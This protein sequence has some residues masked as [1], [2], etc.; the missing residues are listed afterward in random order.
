MAT[1]SSH[2]KASATA[3][4]RHISYHWQLFVPLTIAMW[5]VVAGMGLWQRH[6]ME[7]INDARVREPL[8]FIN[9]RTI[10]AYEN[11]VDPLPFIN[12]MANYYKENPLYKRVCMSVYRDGKLVYNVGDI[13]KRDVA[14]ETTGEMVHVE[15]N[16]TNFFYK[17]GRTSDGR[18]EVYSMMPFDEEISVMLD[19]KS[20]DFWLIMIIIAVVLTV[21]GYY[22]TRH[23]GRNIS[24]LRNFAQKAATS[25][26]FVPS[27]DYAHD[28]LGEISRQIV[29]IYKE[30]LQA[31]KRLKQEHEVAMHAMEEKARV[32]RQLTNNI[33]HELK[34]P[35]GVI[36]GYLDTIMANPDMD[37]A[38][39]DHFLAKAQQHAD[40]L[41]Q[42]VA[43]VTA[44][45]RLQ[46]GGSMINVEDMDFHDIV[47]G[48]ASD[49]EESGTIGDMTFEDDVRPGTYVHGN[50]N[51]LSGMLMNLVRNAVAY[52][53]GTECGVRT[54][55][56]DD[57]FYY[58]EFYDDGKGV[59]EEHLE[60]LFERF[61]RIDAG[62]SRK[63]GGT[64][65]GLP[66][67]QNTIE[68]HGGTIKVRNGEQGGLVFAFSLPKA[69]LKDES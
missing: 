57:R 64:G 19:E 25:P 8:E 60:H 63:V 69:Q 38:S 17:A 42:L 7:I 26:D 6:N 58:F 49:V 5:T 51:L 21:V 16:K 43:D 35:I 33:N 62:R 53:H 12:F 4:K 54:V 29:L 65:L 40:R 13:I 18:V 46:E 37:A 56:E 20:E 9:S 48:V 52:S 32:K 23:F 55:G 31:M 15:D 10:D 28:E 61:Y 66:I 11:D 41:A 68:A 67:V 50:F 36:K 59:G 1:T 30:R 27:A 14:D 39:R 47:Y 22:S 3:L 44:I 45:T 34:T 2:G 24:M